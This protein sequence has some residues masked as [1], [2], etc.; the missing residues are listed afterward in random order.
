MGLRK[1]DRNN[2]WVNW[3]RHYNSCFSSYVLAQEKGGKKIDKNTAGTIIV[4]CLTVLQ[5]Y[6]WFCGHDGGVFA[7]LSGLIGA[8]LGVLFG[9]EINWH[10]GAN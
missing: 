9:I 10:K 5:L 6:A 7:V 2:S 1:N 3:Q 4:I 8:V